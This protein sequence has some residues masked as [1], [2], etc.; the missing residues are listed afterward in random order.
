M[1]AY[2]I[3]DIP[4]WENLSLSMADRG[5]LDR[6]I[7]ELAHRSVPDDVPRDTATPFRKEIRKQLARLT[8]QA[9]QAGAG[10]LCLPTKRMGDIPIPASY[11]VSEWRDAD[12]DEVEP[13]Q[14]L[15]VLAAN[16]IFATRLVDI[17]GQ[18]ALREEGVEAAD[19][20]S[21]PLATHAGRRVSYTIAAPD[22]RRAWVVFTFSTLG[23]GNPEGALAD[24]LVELFD[25]Q[26]TTLRW[27]EE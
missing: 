27:R 12:R 5:D 14:L 23:D 8:D 24:I 10:L 3:V 20:V 1:S 2:S 13:S 22:D 11:T 18:P 16:S 6:R 7:D 25:A 17:D 21:E 19:P 26:L 15:D 4:G 9:R